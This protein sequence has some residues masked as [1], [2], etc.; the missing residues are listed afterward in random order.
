MGA[1]GG[2][3]MQSTHYS[4]GKFAQLS[5][6][7]IRTLHYYE[8][9]GLLHPNRRD[10]GHRIYS[11]A[12]LIHL[13]KIIGLK[14][15]GFSLERIRK[16]IHH[17]EPEVNLIETL[18]LQYQ[19][20]Q[21]ARA[22]LDRSLEILRR[23]I[24]IMQREGKLEHSLM[25]LLIRNI[26]REDKQRSWVEEHLS[27]QTAAVL[28]DISPGAEAE[29]D[30]ELLTFIEAVKRLS[31]GEPDALEA[32]EMLNFYV[33]RTL[34]LLDEKA[35]ANVDHISE[36]EYERLN[37]LVDMPLNEGEIIWLNEALSHYVS[38]FGLPGV[39]EP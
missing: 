13:Q 27:E 9:I 21:E 5:G 7:P 39:G 18:Q 16:C 33:Q 30:R 17:H 2:N 32:E 22:E 24:A 20:M 19:S 12:D 6:V 8:E 23:L 1:K 36:E 10:N 11:T 25:F 37:A 4:I 35:M 28:F 38:K 34:H 14:S 31:T 26:L 3:E 15:L 29:L